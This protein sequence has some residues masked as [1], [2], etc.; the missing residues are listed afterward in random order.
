MPNQQ[1][2]PFVESPKS[3]EILLPQESALTWLRAAFVAGREEL[4]R[5]AGFIGLMGSSTVGSMQEAEHCLNTI[6]AACDQ[7]HTANL[8][9]MQEWYAR[10]QEQGESFEVISTPDQEDESADGC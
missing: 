6:L 8:Q 1:A 7:A 3:L 5:T 10:T 2:E 4:R 9:E